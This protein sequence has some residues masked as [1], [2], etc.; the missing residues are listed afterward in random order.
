[1]FARVRTPART[2]THPRAPARTQT[3]PM[4]CVHRAAAAAEWDRRSARSHVLLITPPSAPVRATQPL[5]LPPSQAIGGPLAF[6]NLYVSGVLEVGPVPEENPS[7][8]AAGM[9]GGLGGGGVPIKGAAGGYPGG[10]AG[11]SASALVAVG[12]LPARLP[13]HL[14]A[15]LKVLNVP[16]IVVRLSL[17]ALHGKSHQGAPG[18]SRHLPHFRSRALP[19]G[20]PLHMPAQALGRSRECPSASR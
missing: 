3:H 14:L 17:S 10:A 20:P 1:M 11:A 15:T 9:G 16:E 18:C 2:H 5:L 7:G 19:R 12:A 6:E 8:V 13:T 4:Q